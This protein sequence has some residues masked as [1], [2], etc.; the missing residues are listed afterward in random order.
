MFSRPLMLRQAVAPVTAL[1]HHP[2]TH[3]HTHTQVCCSRATPPTAPTSSTASSSSTRRCASG[4]WRARCVCVV[5]RRRS[6]SECSAAG[7]RAR[8]PAVA[9]TCTHDLARAHRRSCTPAHPASPTGR[10]RGG[11][12]PHAHAHR[13]DEGEDAAHLPGACVVCAHAWFG[14]DRSVD[15]S[16]DR[17]MD[18]SVDRSMDWSVACCRGAAGSR[19]ALHA[20]TPHARTHAQPDSQQPQYSAPDTPPPQPSLARHS[21]RH[22]SCTTPSRCSSATCTTCR[23]PSSPCRCACARVWWW[24]CG[25]AGACRVARRAARAPAG[26]RKSRAVC[27]WRATSLP[28]PN[29]RAFVRVL[30]TFLV[31]CPPQHTHTH[32]HTHTHTH[33]HT[34]ARARALHRTGACSCCRRA[35]ASARGPPRSRSRSTWRQRWDVLRVRSCAA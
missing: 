32:A 15:W 33:T 18:W 1:H 4:V 16:V 25:G 27:V 11:G 17:S 22:R 20:D 30:T 13:A 35:T 19:P 31:R 5:C 7:R 6:S 3:T 28:A 10:G 26:L 24:W 9:A 34:H 8:P 12:H 23:T 14:L 2:H 29:A 21:T